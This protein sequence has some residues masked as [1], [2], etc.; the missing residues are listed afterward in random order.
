MSAR[1]RA[2]PASRSYTARLQRRKVYRPPRPWPAWLTNAVA[3]W[4]L[5]LTLALV[6]ELGHL[7][8]AVVEWPGSAARGAF[9]VVVA[10]GLGVL[11]VSVYFG[12]ST[13][14]TMVAAVGTALVP[15][16]W[17][18]GAVAGLTPY[19][20]TSIVVA[21]AVTVA[22]AVTAAVMVARWTAR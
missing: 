1:T 7:A 4:H 3:G 18:A 14:D 5:A 13:L 10:G 21:A 19:Q 9:H 2:R 20:E 11:A 6:A 8:A 12:L 22:E 16:L 17:L 15:V